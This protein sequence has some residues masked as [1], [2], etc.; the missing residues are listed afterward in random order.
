MKWGPLER[1]LRPRRAREE[2]GGAEWAFRDACGSQKAQAH[3]T[4]KGGDPAV[5]EGARS[6]CGG[7]DADL[8][9]KNTAPT[10]TSGLR[11]Q[12][13]RAVSQHKYAPYGT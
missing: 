2:Q 13:I 4:R 12:I 1:A 6:G 3:H 11:Q 5:I 9:N 10:V 8:A 7:Q